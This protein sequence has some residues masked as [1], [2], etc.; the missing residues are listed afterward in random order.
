MNGESNGAEKPN[1]EPPV[2]NVGSIDYYDPYKDGRL[3]FCA[4]LPVGTCAW[5]R[6]HN[7]CPAADGV[8]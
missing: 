2:L 5:C 7:F 6:A 8:E 4:I 1:T 3:F